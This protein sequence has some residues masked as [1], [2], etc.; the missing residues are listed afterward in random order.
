MNKK[1]IILEGT[2]DEFDMLRDLYEL[3][4]NVLPEIKEGYQTFNLWHINDVMDRYKCTENEAMEVL[5]KA[6]TNE[7][8]MNQIWFAIDFHAKEEF[9]LKRRV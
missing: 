1:K 6:L 8:T 5:E 3:T 9:D 7:A 2:Q 4:D